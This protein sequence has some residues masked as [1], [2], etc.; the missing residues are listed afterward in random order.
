MNKAVKWIIWLVVI[1]LVVVGIA[2]A[3][4]CFNN[5]VVEEEQ[6]AYMY[7]DGVAAYDAEGARAVEG[8]TG[9]I[10]DADGEPIVVGAATGADDDNG[11]EPNGE[12][13]GAEENGEENGDED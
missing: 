7:V 11:Y 4:G 2:W 9:P 13:N 3:A 6:A 12:E 10:Y 5:E 8:Y 1:A